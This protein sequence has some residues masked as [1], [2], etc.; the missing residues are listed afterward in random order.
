MQ[1]HD[2]RAQLMLGAP[3]GDIRQLQE[4]MLMQIRLLAIRPHE[5]NLAFI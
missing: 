3:A 5:A 1:L 2:R 4:F